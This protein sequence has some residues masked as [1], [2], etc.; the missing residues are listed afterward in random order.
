MD[1][2]EFQE[3]VAAIRDNAHYTIVGLSL[4]EIQTL[5]KR[6]DSDAYHAAQAVEQFFED[7]R[8]EKI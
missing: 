5:N 1:S 8:N 3:L 7:K 4:Q 2:T 6:L